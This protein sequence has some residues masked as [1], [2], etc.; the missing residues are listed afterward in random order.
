MNDIYT[1][2]GLAVEN[3]RDIPPV[4]HQFSFQD[5]DIA[6]HILSLIKDGKDN[7][8]ADKNGSS[9]INNLTSEHIYQIDNNQTLIT[10]D[11]PCIEEI[12]QIIPPNFKSL[13]IS[14]LNINGLKH[15]PAK[16]T[17]ITDFMKEHDLDILGI[18]KT[19]LTKK[20]AL[21]LNK[22]K[23]WVDSDYRIIASNKDPNKIK[24]S[25]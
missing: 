4:Q 12:E 10:S 1:P 16:I 2:G 17:Q 18:N 3:S 6:H 22:N 7:I 9:I 8:C 19:N 23:I 24:G 20:E 25:G 5:Q 21:F 13:K 11:Q 15:D 14:I